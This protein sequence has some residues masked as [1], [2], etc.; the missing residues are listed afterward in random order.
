MTIISTRRPGNL[1]TLAVLSTPAAVALMMLLGSLVAGGGTAHAESNLQ[2]YCTSGVRCSFS[3]SGT[4]P[5]KGDSTIAWVA[6]LTNLTNS[7]TTTVVTDC[8]EPNGALT[9]G[10]PDYPGATLVSQSPANS[11][12]GDLQNGLTCELPASGSVTLDLTTP[13]PSF[14]LP[15]GGCHGGEVSNNLTDNNHSVL[16]SARVYLPADIAA[17]CPVTITPQ[18]AILISKSAGTPVLPAG[19]GSET[20]TYTVTNPGNVPLSN[21]SVSDNTCSP[22]TFVG[23]DTNTNSLLDTSETWTFT[24]TMNITANT[25]NIATATG[26]ANGTKVSAQAQA[27]VTVQTPQT[28]V[29]TLTVTKVVSPAGDPGTFNL[30]IDGN[31]EASSVGNGGTTGPVQVTAGPHTI[32]ET[33]A[34]GTSLS[35]YTTTFSTNCAGGSV[36]VAAGTAVVCT[37]TNTRNTTETSNPPP[38]NPPITLITIPQQPAPTPTATPPARPTEAPQPTATAEPTKTSAVLG[39]KTPGPGATPAPPSA[40]RGRY[41]NWFHSAGALSVIGLFILS[42]ALSGMVLFTTRKRGE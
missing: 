18:P 26:T 28:V 20:Y 7:S 4:V 13:L 5:A 6:T 16:A 36:N 12:T 8:F 9:G 1:R 23:G 3:K 19:G 38:N 17:G 32:S 31:T 10:C 27:S 25:T 33:G 14:A 24:C 39:E 29:Q 21:V 15:A 11:C 22:V 34:N 40:G 35:N 41:S 37:I 42:A 2:Q 30:L